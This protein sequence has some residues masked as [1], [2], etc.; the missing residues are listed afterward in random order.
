MT[1]TP[2]WGEI[3]PKGLPADWKRYRHDYV[4][5]SHVPDMDVSGAALV[6]SDEKAEGP[7]YIASDTRAV[8]Y[9][10]GDVS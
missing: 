3:Q 1:E 2:D 6:I 7:A 4:N 9:V 10:P 8:D 5:A